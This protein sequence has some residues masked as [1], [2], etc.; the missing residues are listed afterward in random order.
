MSESLVAAMRVVA[1]KGRKA[2]RPG[3]Y[4]WSSVWWHL[5]SKFERSGRW[6]ST[7][8]NQETALRSIQYSRNML[9]LY[10][11]MRDHPE[12]YARKPQYLKGNS[13]S[14]W[15]WMENRT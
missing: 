7:T 13:V 11:D 9:I 3:C 15:Q 2:G 12:H 14:D 6:G 5:Q 4:R 8:A 1:E 10:R